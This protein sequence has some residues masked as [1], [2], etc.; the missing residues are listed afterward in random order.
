MKSI[1]RPGSDMYLKNCSSC[2]ESF[3]TPT[4]RQKKCNPECG[5]SRSRGSRA[6]ERKAQR[7]KARAE[8]RDHNLQFIG[9]DGE[10]VNTHEWWIDFDV[11]GEEFQVKV[12]VHNY[13]LLSVG[14][15][16]LHKDG[17]KLN[18][19]EIFRF[20]YDQYEENPNAVFLGYFLGY[21]F[22]MWFKSLPARAAWELLTPAGMLRRESLVEGVPRWPV[23]DATEIRWEHRQK[24]CVGA[25]WEFDTI[26]MKQLK[27]RPYVPR[28]R[29][30]DCTVAHKSPLEIEACAAG[31][32]R[33]HPHNWMFICDA[34]SFF[35]TKFT[36]AIDPKNWT[37]PIV[38]PEEFSLISQGKDRRADAKFDLDMIEYNV[39]E[40]DVLGRLMTRINEGF[41]E[42]S[43][44]LSKRQW[45]GPGQAA[46]AWMKLVGVPKGEEIREHVPL[47]AREAARDTYYG[48]WFEI[49]SHGPVPGTSYNYDINSAYPAIIAELPCLLHG[50]WT[51]S[52]TTKPRPLKDREIR[53]LYLTVEGED[54]VVGPLQYRRDDG[55][56]CR[57]WKSR[58]WHWQ[59]EVEA[60]QRAGLITK[61]RIHQSVTYTPCDCPPPMAEIRGLYDGRLRAG[62]NS[63]QGKGKKLVYNSAYG[64]CCQSIGQPQFS[65][66]VWASLITAGCRTMILDAIATHP[67]KTQSLLMIATDGIVF[68]EPHPGLD[69]DPERLG[70]WDAGEYQNL[71][72]FMPGVYWHDEAREAIRA[73][74]VP[75]LKSRGVAPKDLGKIID[76]V[77]RLWENVEPNEHGVAY[78][79]W[80]T[81]RMDVDFVLTSAKLAITRGAWETCGNVSHDS[82]RDLSG[83]P[84]RKRTVPRPDSGIGLRKFDDLG[85]RTWPIPEE[86]KLETT[87]YSHRFGDPEL[88]ERVPMAF[89]ED[90][91]G[92]VDVEEYFTPD[93]V[94]TDV[95]KWELV[96]D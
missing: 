62:K 15:K 7:A 45:Y 89:N 68:K 60:A 51:R 61:M 56:I 19:R 67:T 80:P 81:I 53:M 6:T 52:K 18:H 2:G 69:I 71:S 14:D 75:K 39:L 87:Y 49:F 27:I 22:T 26:G 42:D 93:G 90:D 95:W 76:K 32:H 25:Q 38:T 43:I 70:A 13:V 30:L 44:R 72:L 24:I 10:G 83:N 11:N 77:D 34:G 85:W 16:S 74:K 46:Q 78:W 50:K 54:P 66:P 63:P 20:L 37:S 33:R 5:R 47:W 73:N 36:N 84:D 86:E 65:N 58:G 4:I 3:E 57:P 28:S 91:G 82:T 41:V 23:N 64:K 79:K 8:G 12:P 40:N 59:H 1:R 94:L 31:R 48:G 96:Q 9:V 35:Q 55:S 29:Y 88:E 17:K 21:D 92:L